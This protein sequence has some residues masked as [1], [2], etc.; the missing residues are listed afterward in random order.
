MNINLTKLGQIAKNK[1]VLFLLF[2]AVVSVIWAVI[3][4]LQKASPTTP[5]EFL[6]ATKQPVTDGKFDE[7]AQISQSSKSELVKAKEKLPYRTIVESSTGNRITLTLYQL[8]GDE[9]TLYAEMAP[10]E[11]QSTY[12]D[13]QLPKNILDFRETATVIYNWLKENNVDSSKI[14]ISWGS[15]AYV[16]KNA[17]AWLNVSLQ[18]PNVIK[19]DNNFVFE[20]EPVKQ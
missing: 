8:P 11:F 17:A 5:K 1:I 7:N 13:P 18:Y 14:F 3:A 20:T 2:L 15:K 4:N 6:P 16:Q 10:I 19:K 9:F 12:E